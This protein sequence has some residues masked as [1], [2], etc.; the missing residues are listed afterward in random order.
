VHPLHDPID[1]A[2]D[3]LLALGDSSKSHSDLGEDVRQPPVL[4][5]VELWGDAVVDVRHFGPDDDEVRLGDP[6][7][8]RFK[9]WSTAL[10]VLLLGGA[11][12]LTTMHA[13]LPRPTL[14]PAGDADLVEEWREERQAE[15]A[16]I[17]AQAR[18]RAQAEEEALARGEE[19]PE[20]PVVEE[21]TWPD[22]L[23]EAKVAWEAEQRETVTRL[24]EE[25]ADAI[26]ID[27][28]RQPFA[29]D[30]L[31][32]PDLMLVEQM[33]PIAR[34]Q[35]PEGRLRRSWADVLEEW[36]TEDLALDSELAGLLYADAMARRAI[37][38]QCRAL[39]RME[40]LGDL[41]GDFDRLS[42]HARCLHRRSRYDEARPATEAALEHR[43]GADAP[44]EQLAELAALLR[45]DAELADLEA[46]ADLEARER[47]RASWAEVGDLARASLHDPDLLIVADRG[48]HDA[49]QH[50]RADS[51]DGL[52]KA[53]MVLSAFVALMLPVGFIVD[54]RRSHRG[55]PHFEV[56]SWDLPDD[57]FKLAEREGAALYVGFTPD[58]PTRLRTAAGGDLGTGD[59]PERAGT[60]DVGGWRRTPLGPGDT[61]SIQL[62]GR[63]FVVRTR[64][65]AAAVPGKATDDVDWRFV[66]VMAA[67]ILLGASVGVL[68]KLV[69]F[70]PGTEILVPPIAQTVRLA[71]VLPETPE[72]SGSDPGERARDEEG[73]RG[74]PTSDRRAPEARV[75]V[76]KA[77]Q[78]RAVVND[79]ISALL[80]GAPVDSSSLGTDVRAAATG[81]HG[82]NL[83]YGPG[84]WGI[85][86][87]GPGGG[88]DRLIGGISIDG[89]GTGGPGGP[90]DGP[91][92]GPIKRVE[93]Q[94]TVSTSG[95]I[96]IGG[97]RK[98]QIDRVV[99]DHLQAIRYC[100]QRELQRQPD[101]HGKV[102]IKF[103]ID[104]FGAVSTST[105]K[106]TSMDHPVVEKCVADRF[107]RMRFPRPKG[108]GIVIVSYPFVFDAAGG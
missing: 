77:D 94:P 97:I 93:K 73:A 51:Q 15:R 76:R 107:F 5:V 19:L 4:E 60:E 65:A 45:V 20:E 3:A 53:A 56:P 10:L 106:S 55:A 7:H 42:Q 39:E 67:V 49:A 75:A 23:A 33:L 48:L 71:P 64:P 41:D 44:P 57:P 74:D 29:F 22:P 72:S 108:D 104:R 63:V 66:A 52:I 26:D 40:P 80:D 36:E 62:G 61:F 30:K 47:A 16:A 38:Q 28:A 37:G 17:V 1:R 2:E 96:A 43:P 34:E 83:A 6:R 92:D 8:R 46:G 58:A 84:G 31:P 91:W 101:L 50:D 14:L 87:G 9:P 11:A 70:G 85:R 79:L 24:V 90:G 88:G 21:P 12:V 32:E 105:V 82:A 25:G 102:V 54:E 78:D 89:A 100:Y 27:I 98:D 35:A 18:L 69:D 103:V 86:G 68:S 59:L 99:K 81:L 95:G 13:T